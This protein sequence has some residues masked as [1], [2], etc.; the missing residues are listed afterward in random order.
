MVHFLKIWPPYFQDV[1][2][3]IKTFEVRYND[4]PYKVGDILWLQE[5]NPEKKEYTGNFVIAKVTYLLDEPAFVKDGFVIL[6]IKKEEAAIHFSNYGI[7]IHI[8]GH[9]ELVPPDEVPENWSILCQ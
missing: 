1:V 8:N 5:Y 4:R 3:G 2:S 6:G 9:I 7:E